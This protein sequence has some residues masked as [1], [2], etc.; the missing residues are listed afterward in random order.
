MN[1]YRRKL[2]LLVADSL[3]DQ[4]R[5]LIAQLI[6]E[7]DDVTDRCARLSAAL[8]QKR[9]ETEQLKRKLNDLTGS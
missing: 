8:T 9:S 5:D 7:H 6:V 4:A 2:I 1:D 3:D